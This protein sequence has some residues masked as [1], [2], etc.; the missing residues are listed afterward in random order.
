MPRLNWTHDQVRN[1]LYSVSSLHENVR[2]EIA[3]LIIKLSDLDDWYPDALRRKLH[4]LQ[5]LGSL[6]E[7][8]RHTIEK[9]FFPDHVW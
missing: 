8:D 7:I 1:K 3:E 4:A 2:H 9:T 6:K 5:D